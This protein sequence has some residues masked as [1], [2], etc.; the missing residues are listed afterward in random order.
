MAT[1]MDLMR[2]EP[3]TGVLTP[4]EDFQRNQEEELQRYK[5]RARMERPRALRDSEK[6]NVFSCFRCRDAGSLCSECRAKELLAGSHDYYPGTYPTYYLGTYLPTLV[7]STYT[8]YYPGRVPTLPT[9]VDLRLPGYLPYLLPA[10]VPTLPTLVDTITLVPTLPTL[11]DSDYYPGTY[12]TY[13]QFTVTITRVPTLPTR[14]WR[15]VVG[16]LRYNQ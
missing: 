16:T 4:M 3:G 5:A 13:H 15:S 8:T 2:I 12:P 11:V 6:D 1:A 9:L 14:R 10:G 7:D